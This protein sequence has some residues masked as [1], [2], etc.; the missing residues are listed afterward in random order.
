MPIGSTDVQGCSWEKNVGARQ[1]APQPNSAPSTI[2]T[3]DIRVT[4]NTIPRNVLEG[5]KGEV[6]DMGTSHKTTNNITAGRI[7]ISAAGGPIVPRRV[8]DSQANPQQPW[9]TGLPLLGGKVA[10]RERA[11]TDPD[12]ETPGIQRPLAEFEVWG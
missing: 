2:P 3:S 8:A 5:G 12:N 7:P 4:R 1:P 11:G 6:F 9:P 10:R